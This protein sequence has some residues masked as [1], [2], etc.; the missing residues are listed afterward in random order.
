[1]ATQHVA[2]QVEHLQL[3]QPPDLTRHRPCVN[4]RVT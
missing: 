2:V 3:G 4:M 1:L